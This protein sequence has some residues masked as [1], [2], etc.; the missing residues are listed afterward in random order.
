[1][2][3]LHIEDVGQEFCCMFLMTMMSLYAHSNSFTNDEAE[4]EALL[5][6]LISALQTGI[7]SIQGEQAHHQTSTENLH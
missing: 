4:Y 7:R 6:G 3:F 2:V 1:M 5:I